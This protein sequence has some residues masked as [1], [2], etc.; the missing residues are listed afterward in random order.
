MEILR[1]VEQ[2]NLV[3]NGALQELQNQQINLLF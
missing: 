2:E 3:W 1:Y